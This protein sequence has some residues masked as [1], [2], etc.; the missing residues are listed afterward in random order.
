[1]TSKRDIEF[2]Y[3]SVKEGKFL[4]SYNVPTYGEDSEFFMLEGWDNDVFEQFT[5]VYDIMDN[6]IFEG[7]IV[8]GDFYLAFEGRKTVKGVITY[9]PPTFV[10]NSNNV[11]LPNW[12]SAESIYVVGNI[13][14]NAELI[15]NF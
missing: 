4:S 14:E 12:V 9:V 10:L 6:K 3:W 5:G 15:E 13:H 2:R 7:D 1:M 8:S 11:L